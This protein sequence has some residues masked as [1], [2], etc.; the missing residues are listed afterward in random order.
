MKLTLLI[1]MMLA[2]GAVTA[3]DAESVKEGET[4][5][6][7]D[8][9]QVNALRDPDFKT[10][11]AFVAGLDAFDAKHTLAPAAALRFL[12]RPSAPDASIEGVTIRIAGND[13]SI[14]VPLAADGTF[15]MPRSQAAVD[16]DAEIILNRKKG[17]FRWR[18]DVRTPHV[19]ANARRLGDLRLEC[20]V[21]WA[22]ERKDMSFAKRTMISA[23]GGPCK[24]A[25]VH[26]MNLAPRTITGYRMVAG[27]RSETAP[28]DAVK[29]DKMTY[30]APLSDASWPDDALVEFEFG[31]EK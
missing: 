21:R 9:V 26:V 29:D 30:V 22:V 5:K 15:V 16:E 3:Q 25:R 14:A 1:A 19:P 24:T 8:T 17:S 27:Q 6:D 28:A 31:G 4:V 11:R 13:T 20:E 23:L 10:Y 2:A 18:P 7:V 12:L